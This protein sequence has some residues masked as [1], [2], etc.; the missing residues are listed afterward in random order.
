MLRRRR[1][2]IRGARVTSLWGANDKAST[3]ISS[4]ASIWERTRF[5]LNHWSAYKASESHGSCVFCWSRKINEFKKT[6]EKSLKIEHIQPCALRYSQVALIPVLHSS[7]PSE[8]AF[9]D[10][11]K[12]IHTSDLFSLHTVWKVGSRV[13]QLTFHFLHRDTDR[14]CSWCRSGRYTLK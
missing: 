14:C 9:W 12:L 11:S 2:W 10:E 7:D 4:T 8:I 5:A 1:F 3:P 6:K 13:R